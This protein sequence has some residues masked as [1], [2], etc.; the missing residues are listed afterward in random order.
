MPKSME[1]EVWIF[2]SWLVITRSISD[3]ELAVIR[4]GLFMMSKYWR[5]P[6]VRRAL[7][8]LKPSVFLDAI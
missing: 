7:V 6:G 5:G 1:P 3:F 2:E 4:V 8:Q